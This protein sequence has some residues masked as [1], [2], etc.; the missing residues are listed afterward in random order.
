MLVFSLTLVASCQEA[1]ETIG[2]I[3]AQF[4]ENAEE[5]KDEIVDTAGDVKE[6]IVETVADIREKVVK[7]QKKAQKH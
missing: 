6:E 7:I 3:K 5:F 2:E 4:A 1:K